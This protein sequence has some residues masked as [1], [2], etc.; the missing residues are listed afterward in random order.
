MSA[1]VAERIA[2]WME[3]ALAPKGSEFSYDLTV[4]ISPNGP[5]IAFVLYLKGAILGQ[6]IYSSTILENPAGIT[7]EV[8]FAFVDQVCAKLVDQRSSQLTSAT[9]EANG[10]PTL[11]LP[12]S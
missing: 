7:E 6:T 4:A 11:H 12:N 8:V 5:V 2:G 9:V 3:E 10:H 1:R